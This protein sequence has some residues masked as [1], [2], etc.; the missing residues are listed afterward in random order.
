MCVTLDL[1]MDLQVTKDPLFVLNL[2]KFSKTFSGTSSADFDV[3]HWL[4]SFGPPRLQIW[5]KLCPQQSN[6]IG[7]DLATLITAG[8]LV[9]ILAHTPPLS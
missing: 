8:E 3:I 1:L 6:P 2:K 9:D 7:I 5:A 4:R